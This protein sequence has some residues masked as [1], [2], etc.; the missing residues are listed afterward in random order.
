[1]EE[2]EEKNEDTEDIDTSQALSMVSNGDKVK[3]M[4]T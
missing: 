3:P 1:L 2:N 4:S